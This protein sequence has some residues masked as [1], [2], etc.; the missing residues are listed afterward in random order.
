MFDHHV[1]MWML[2]RAAPSQSS[3]YNHPFRRK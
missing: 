2:W 1:I 3:F